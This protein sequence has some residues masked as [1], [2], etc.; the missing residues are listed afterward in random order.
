[1]TMVSQRRCIHVATRPTS[2]EDT[3]I[4]ACN[5]SRSTI[6]SI[7]EDRKVTCTLLAHDLLL[8]AVGKASPHTNDPHNLS[9]LGLGVVFSGLIHVRDGEWMALNG[10]D[11]WERKEEVLAGLPT[12]TIRPGPADVQGNVERAADGDA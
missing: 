12:H 4:K 1:M 10:S 9:L 11:G 2:N 7:H 5:I 8:Q 3:S 6:W